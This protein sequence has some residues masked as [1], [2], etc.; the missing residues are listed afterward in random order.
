MLF[1]WPFASQAH[2][3]RPAV[4]TVTLSATAAEVEMRLTLEPLVA[5]MDLNGLDDINNSPLAGEHDRLRALDPA[6]LEALF[7][8][9]WPRIASGLVMRAGDT[10]LG[11]ALRDVVITPEPDLELPRDATLTFRADLP[12]DD[13]P[14]VMG[15]ASEY[16]PLVIRQ[17][18]GADAYTA[19]LDQGT[20]SDPMPRD[21]TARLGATAAFVAYL[22]IGFEHI[23]PKGLDHI[24]FVLGL[25]F[26]SLA[27]R[28]LLIQVTTFTLAHTI[29]LAMATLGIVTVPASVVEPLIAASIVY[30]AVENV[31]GSAMTWRR[32]AVVFAFGLLHGLGFASVLGDI[33]L[34]PARFIS[35]LIAFNIGVEIGQLAVIAIAFLAVGI[36]FGKKT[37]YRP[38]IAVPAS[39]MIG[40]VGAYWAIERV[41]V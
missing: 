22:V 13:T 24:L 27:I 36:W 25:F 38:Y 3:V 26:F 28:P 4:A 39:V 29:T 7:R 35:G 15:W 30:I 5:G 21:G 14:L 11:P 20:L 33:G 40:L 23:I 34:D 37:W 1:A 41:L 17:G 6:T 9:N 32:I 2:E 16:G 10:R 19:F 12:A 31:I 18:D 8:E